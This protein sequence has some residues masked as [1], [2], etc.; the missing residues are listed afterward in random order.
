[1]CALIDDPD[2]KLSQLM[3]LLPAPDFPTG[4]QLLDTR[5]LSQVYKEGRGKAT[6]RAKVHKE[7]ITRKGQRAVSERGERGGRGQEK[8]REKQRT[9]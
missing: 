1:M 2:I 8:Q 6:L 5:G 7:T 4:G 9:P 3:A